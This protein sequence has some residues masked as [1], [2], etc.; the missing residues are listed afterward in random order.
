MRCTQ[1]FVNT[2]RKI[3]EKIEQGVLDVSNEVRPIYAFLFVAPPSMSRRIGARSDVALHQPRRRMASGWGMA[4]AGATTTGRSSLTAALL[5][6]PSRAAADRAVGELGII[7]TRGSLSARKR[8]KRW[9][10][11]VPSQP[12]PAAARGGSRRCHRWS[13]P[14]RGERRQRQQAARRCWKDEVCSVFFR[15]IVCR[16]DETR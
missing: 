15:E 11:S 1:A 7:R 16:S 10:G 4:L 8:S 13:T 14:P 2:A 6:K 3:Y 9:R 5:L 12:A